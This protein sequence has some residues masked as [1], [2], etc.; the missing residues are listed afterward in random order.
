MTV[1]VWCRY[2]RAASS[3]FH[4]HSRS[5]TW[6]RPFLSCYLRLPCQAME[7]M[8]MV[9]RAWIGMMTFQLQGIQGVRWT[10]FLAS[11]PMALQMV[12]EGAAGGDT[13]PTAWT[14]PQ[15]SSDQ[16][17]QC[18]VHGIVWHQSRCYRSMHKSRGDA[19]MCLKLQRHG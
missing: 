19:C 11:C 15:A 1:W 6:E 17:K 2:G 16:S 8:V 9:P 5:Q 14:R 10:A 13:T 3:P 7:R 4:T 18:R 12:G